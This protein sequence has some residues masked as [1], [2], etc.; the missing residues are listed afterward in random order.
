[1]ILKVLTYIE[2]SLD[3][4]KVY[5]PLSNNIYLDVTVVEYSAPEGTVYITRENLREHTSLLGLVKD[6]LLL[7]NKAVIELNI[8]CSEQNNVNNYG[9]ERNQGQDAKYDGKKRNI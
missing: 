2:R 5:I 7:N 6:A 4:G 1:M 9:D 3:V 8:L